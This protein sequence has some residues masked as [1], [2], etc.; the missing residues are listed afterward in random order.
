MADLKPAPDALSQKFMTSVIFAVVVT[1]IYFG[2]AVLMPLALA[3]LMSFA[4]A[5]VVSVLR[6]IRLGHIPSVLLS[7][8][9]ALVVIAG[10]GTYVGSQVAGLA[11]ALPSYQNNI[12]RKIVS[13]RGTADGGTLSRLNRT[14]EALGDQLRRRQRTFFHGRRRRRH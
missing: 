12:S 3:V 5:P 7:L 4:L 13:I 11:N 6:R 1:G 10:V 14:I 2:R 9:L 8:A